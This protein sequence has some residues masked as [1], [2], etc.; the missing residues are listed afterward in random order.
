MTLL[1]PRRSPLSYSVAVGVALGA[2]TALVLKYT[3]TPERAPRP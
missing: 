1:D 3:Y 2:R